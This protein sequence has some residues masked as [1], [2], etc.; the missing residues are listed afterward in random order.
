MLVRV[1]DD[2][3]KDT[4]SWAVIYS[5]IIRLKGRSGY[6]LLCANCRMTRKPKI[7]TAVFSARIREELYQKAKERA[8]EARQSLGQFL[9]DVL[10]KL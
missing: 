4:R 5:E 1:V 9:E 8:R 10:A 6:E 3:Q 2:G 7:R